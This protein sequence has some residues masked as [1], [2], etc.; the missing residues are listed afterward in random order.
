MKQCLCPPGQD[1]S[2][3]SK[4]APAG[5]EPVSALDYR[6]LV[7]VPGYKRDTFSKTPPSL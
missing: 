5:V 6:P 2:N 3:M 1:F 4:T 7:S